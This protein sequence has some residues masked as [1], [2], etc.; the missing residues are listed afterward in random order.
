M[1]NNSINV[2]LFSV[3]KNCKLF[4]CIYIY[5]RYLKVIYIS[6]CVTVLNRLVNSLTSDEK[7]SVPTIESKFRELC[8]SAKK[9]ENRFVSFCNI[10][11]I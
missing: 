1:C 5:E 6:V 11:L 4:K 8:L 9:A 10:L 2:Q 3:M 7:S